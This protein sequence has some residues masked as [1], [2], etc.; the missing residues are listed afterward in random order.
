MDVADGR[1][2]PVG[3]AICGRL[4]RIRCFWVGRQLGVADR[5]K[6][7]RRADVASGVDGLVVERVDA[8]EVR[9][10]CARREVKRC[11]DV[12]WAGHRDRQARLG[13][14]V[15][16]RLDV[17]R[18]EL[19]TD[20]C[21]GCR[22]GD[23]PNHR[24]DGVVR[25]AAGNGEAI[26]VHVI[27]RVGVDTSNRDA[28]RHARRRVATAVNV[29]TNDPGARR[30]CR[31]GEGRS[32][33]R[34]RTDEVTVDVDLLLGTVEGRDHVHPLAVGE[35][36]RWQR[37]VA[38]RGRVCVNLDA[39]MLRIRPWHQLKAEAGRLH[40]AH[41]VDVPARDRGVD[42]E[43]RLERRAVVLQRVVGVGPRSAPRL[44]TIEVRNPLPECGVVHRGATRWLRREWMRRSRHVSRNAAVG[45]CD[46]EQVSGRQRRTHR[47]PGHVFLR[48]C[49]EHRARGDQRGGRKANRDGCGE[50]AAKP[51][52]KQRWV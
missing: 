21:R 33:G 5:D 8:V 30:G 45:E 49:C 39:A 24:C 31:G 22:G 17:W 6:V 12:V 50:P 14:E 10:E 23:R 37:A 28:A 20:R 29:A 2:R 52:A 36:R 18:H 9:G 4:R 51:R 16:D 26:R 41:D 11:G 35:G 15:V 43:D 25:I 1:K 46:V 44:R 47:I 34:G 19:H 32:A 27:D 38:A 48:W 40:V 7:L 13:V 42:L 3:H